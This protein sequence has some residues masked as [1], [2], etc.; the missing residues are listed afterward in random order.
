MNRFL[1]EY[2]L[3]PVLLF[4]L[5]VA[6]WE[7]VVWW[8]NIGAYL[9]PAPHAVALALWEDRAKL[10][11]AAS[12]TLTAAAAAFA[13]SFAIGTLVAMAFAQSAILRRAGFPYAIFLQTVPI[14]AIAP[15][16]IAVLGPN[17]RSVVLVAVIIS[18]F[19]IITNV[20]AGLLAVD[21]K[22]VELFA[23][24]RASRWQRLL[25]LQIPTA[26]PHAITGARTSSGLAMVGA[27]VGEFF[28][29]YGGE[30]YGLGYLIS[31]NNDYLRTDK[32]F[33]AVL[34]A[35]LLGI[36]IFG[37]VNLIAGLLLKRWTQ[38]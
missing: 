7:F 28:A 12:Y 16:V 6:L 38:A 22:L 14:V 5:V 27:I 24:L 34:V 36:A 32:L 9:L 2:L 15:L 21:P 26:I 10:F 18:L 17:L 33:A 19:P 37:A 8:F 11:N 1:L 31:T 30:R 29:G 20:T 3:P 23:V 35:A 13:I 25:K 4:A